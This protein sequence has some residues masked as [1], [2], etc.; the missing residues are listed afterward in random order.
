LGISGLALHDDLLHFIRDWVVIIWWRL[1]K[2]QF[3]SI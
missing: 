2:C 3:K 1:T